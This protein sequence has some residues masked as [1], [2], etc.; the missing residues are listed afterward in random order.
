MTHQLKKAYS[1]NKPA[2]DKNT[3]HF[4]IFTQIT[5]MWSLGLWALLP[6]IKA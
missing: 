1:S 5:L 3:L 2:A 4:T 6:E